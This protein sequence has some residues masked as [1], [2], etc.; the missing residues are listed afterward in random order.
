MHV[1][2]LES[3][4][5]KGMRDLDYDNATEYSRADTSEEDTFDK[6]VPSR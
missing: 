2:S 1:A 4:E 6:R 3:K 5:T